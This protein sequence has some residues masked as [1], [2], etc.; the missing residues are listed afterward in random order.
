MSAL[1][2]PALMAARAVNEAPWRPLRGHLKARCAR[3]SFWF[4]APS[5]GGVQQLC[6]RDCEGDLRRRR[7]RLSA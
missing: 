5:A 6:C 1:V 3:C 7:R 2:A 4:S